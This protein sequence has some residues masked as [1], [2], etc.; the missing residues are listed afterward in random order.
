MCFYQCCFIYIAALFISCLEFYQLETQLI[1]ALNKCN[2][3]GKEQHLTV[4]DGLMLQNQFTAWK[5]L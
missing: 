4:L 5:C 2:K 3:N 1:N